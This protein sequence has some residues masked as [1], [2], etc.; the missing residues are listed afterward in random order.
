ML[1]IM[2]WCNAQQQDSNPLEYRV[3]SL[4]QDHGIYQ[5]LKDFKK[6]IIKNSLIKD[7]GI[8]RQVRRKDH[9]PVHHHSTQGCS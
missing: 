4:P 6:V 2:S 5:T 9:K 1:E 8:G 7:L 3:V